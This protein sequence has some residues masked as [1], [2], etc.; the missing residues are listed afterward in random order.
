[1]FSPSQHSLDGS[2]GGTGALRILV[3]EDDPS[4][5]RA[6][7]R[8]LRSAGIETRITSALRDGIDNLDWCH[9]ALVD[10][11]LPDGCG[12]DLLRA[13]RLS[14][15]RVRIAVCS[16][17]LD[18]DAIVA[19]SGERPDAVFRKPLDL[20]RLLEWVNGPAESQHVPTAA[21]E[22]AQVNAL[23]VDDH[24]DSCEVL[25]RL[26]HKL[27][28]PAECVH[29]GADALRYVAERAPAIVFLDWTMPHMSG[30]EV[31]RALRADPRNDDLTVVMYSAL[32]DPAARAAALAAGAQA[33]VVKGRFDEIEAAVGVYLNPGP[34]AGRGNRGRRYLGIEMLS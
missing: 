8:G 1:M 11:D 27:Q 3:V 26:L 25:V 14:S 13:V 6:L 16:G 32:S 2:K 9:V 19:A 23:V 10:L 24:P 5:C 21:P 17:R 28:G 7:G 15:R 20:D 34:T 12:T 4:V 18:A 30:L 33:F 22:R 29:N 31:L